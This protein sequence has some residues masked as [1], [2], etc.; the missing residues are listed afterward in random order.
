MAKTDKKFSERQHFKKRLKERF[1][2]TVNR[3]DLK[4]LVSNILSG[5]NVTKLMKQSNRI[6]TFRTRIKD[7][8]VIVVFDKIRKAPVTCLTQKMFEEGK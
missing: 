4:D 5:T 6:A 2:I 7:K 1:D 8:S 3:H